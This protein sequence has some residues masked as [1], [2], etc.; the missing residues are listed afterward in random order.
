MVNKVRNKSSDALVQAVFNVAVVGDALVARTAYR[1]SQTTALK[2]VVKYRSCSLANQHRQTSSVVCPLATNHAAIMPRICVYS[3]TWREDAW[4]IIVTSAVAISEGR[5]TRFSTGVWVSTWS[6]HAGVSSLCRDQTCDR[7]SAG[8]Q[9]LSRRSRSSHLL[10]SR[11]H[12]RFQ[13]LSRKRPR[14]KWAWQWRA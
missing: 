2:T 10:L 8:D 11:T 9:A 6:S 3:S 13:F 1:E 5:S 12:P 14:D 4:L 7:S